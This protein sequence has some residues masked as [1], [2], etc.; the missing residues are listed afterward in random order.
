[1]K[2][3]KVFSEQIIGTNPRCH[4]VVQDIFVCTLDSHFHQVLRC[5][6]EFA[7]PRIYVSTKALK[8]SYDRRRQFSELNISLLYETL[9]RPDYIC[10]NRIEYEGKTILKRGDFIFFKA[11]SNDK[12]FFACPVEVTKSN[13]LSCVSFFPSKLSYIKKFPTLWDREDGV[14]PPS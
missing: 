8:H 10:N 12:K 14:Y 1:M 2:Y 6:K 7:I 4:V 13:K 11:I 9:K 5:E 3:K